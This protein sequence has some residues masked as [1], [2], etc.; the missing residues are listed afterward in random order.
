MGQPGWA[1]PDCPGSFCP[2]VGG[3]GS[4]PQGLVG[5]E[6]DV[7]SYDGGIGIVGSLAELP[8][9]DVGSGCVGS[10]LMLQAYA[11]V[12]GR[13]CAM[14][15]PG[16]RSVRLERVAAGRYAVT[17]VRG[18]TLTLG[19]GDDAEFTPVEALLAAIAGCT[20]VDVDE[21]TTRRSEPK[22]F[23]VDCEGIK[24]SDDD[25]SHLSKVDITF[26]LEFPDTDQ[27]R[28][29]AGMVERVVR[30]SHEKLCTV[31]RTVMLP[32]PVRSIV[33]DTVIDGH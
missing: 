3:L 28:A 32:T 29:A 25:G 16:L 10:V 19:R 2:Y 22:S 5:G 27:G 33:G 14:S 18:G 24:V 9:G 23:V 7:G 6:L 20:S 21:V 30:L 11:S 17:N 8:N 1:Y 26:R 12:R 13:L 31:S 4:L 15:E